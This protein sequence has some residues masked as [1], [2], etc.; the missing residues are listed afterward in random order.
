MSELA[1]T[2]T[3]THSDEGWHVH[4]RTGIAPGFGLEPHYSLLEVIDRV[5]TLYP[6]YRPRLT[7]TQL[8]D[9]AFQLKI[10]KIIRQTSELRDSLIDL[11]KSLPNRSVGQNRGDFADRLATLHHQLS[12]LRAHVDIAKREVVLAKGTQPAGNAMGRDGQRF[13]TVR[14]ISKEIEACTKAFPF[15]IK[16]IV[17]RVRPHRPPSAAGP[18]R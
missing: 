8:A 18:E 17:G 14:D 4:F 13:P 12:N 10:D 15:G 1:K 9:Y 6:Q 3:L 16:Q 2:Y 7:I 11:A 5:E